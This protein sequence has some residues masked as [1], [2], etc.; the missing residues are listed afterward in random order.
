MDVLNLIDE[1]E[2]IVEA[3]TSLPFTSKVM[4]DKEELLDS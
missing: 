1:V 2:D 4:V 3:G